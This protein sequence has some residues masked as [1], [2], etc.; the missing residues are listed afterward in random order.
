MADEQAVK[1]PTGVS[2]LRLFDLS[3]AKSIGRY[4]LKWVKTKKAWVGIG[5]TFILFLFLAYIFSYQAGAFPAKNPYNYVKP[6]GGIGELEGAENGSAS[7]SDYA[8]E[9]TPMEDTIELNGTKVFRLKVIVEWTDEPNAGLLGRRLVNQADNFE[10]EVT[11][12]D[13]KTETKQGSGTNTAPGSITLSFDWVST[14]GMPLGDT[15][16]GTTN[17]VAV[18]V[19]CTDAGDQA[20]R[21]SPFGL[22]TR[23]DGGNDYTLTVNYLYMPE[24]AK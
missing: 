24:D 2:I 17:S 10:V 16:L 13:G 5:G 3:L 9:G 1:E 14:G 11:L 15:K 4:L 20:P 22:R 21:F 19:T 18:K 12:P 8:A 23:A 6:N 7:I